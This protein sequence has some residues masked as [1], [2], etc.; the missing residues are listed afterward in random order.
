LVFGFPFGIWDGSCEQ[1]TEWNGTK[2]DGET[3]EISKL[4]TF[5]LLCICSF[6]KVIEA[7]KLNLE[8]INGYYEDDK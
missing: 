8:T 1:H 2:L 4:T 3:F 6:C 7:E 5:L